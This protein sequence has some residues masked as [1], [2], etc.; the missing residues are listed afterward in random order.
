VVLL[1]V[2]AENPDAI[3][4]VTLRY[5]DVVY[6]RNGVARASLTV[7]NSPRVP[8]PLERNVL[9][10]LVAWE[11]ARQARQAGRSLAAGDPQ[12]ARSQLATLRELI[13]GLRREV[14]GWSSDLDLAADETMLAEYLEILN[15]P[16]IGDISQR[17]YL[18]D[19]LRY[20]AFRKLQ[21]AAR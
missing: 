11:F 20:A 16:A 15:S 4:D 14:A 9:K 3:A 1:D 21:S 17:R 19:S 7:G 12:Q 2:I 8:G 18:A 10:N 13:H 6:L 5:K